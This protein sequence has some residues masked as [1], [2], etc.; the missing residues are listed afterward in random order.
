MAVLTV[1]LPL[2]PC[3][4]QLAGDSSLDNKY[5]ILDEPRPDAT[6][7]YQHVLR[8]PK[9]AGSV[10][11]CTEPLCLAPACPLHAAHACLF[12]HVPC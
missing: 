9:M 2:D 10:A 7:G 11:L 4:C 1:V 3:H 12:S 5:W 8:P 6:N